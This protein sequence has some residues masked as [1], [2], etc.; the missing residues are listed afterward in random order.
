MDESICMW[1]STNPGIRY[2]PLRLIVFLALIPG[3][4]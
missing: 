4:S 3:K 1:A 2:L